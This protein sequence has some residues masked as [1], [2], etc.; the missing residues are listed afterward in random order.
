[1]LAQ[2]TAERAAVHRNAL[3]TGKTLA[4]SPEA[5]KSDQ[6][7]R[8]EHTPTRGP[9]WRLSG[10]S[11][12]APP[13]IYRVSRDIGGKGRSAVS[14]AHEPAEVEADSLAD[15]I[16][17]DPA[18]DW[19]AG[20][21][22]T[23]P[24]AARS[25]FSSRLGHD[26]GSVRVH[27]GAEAA[28]RADGIGARAFTLNSNIYFAQRRFNLQSREGRRL[29]AH[30]LIHIQQQHDGRI[31]TARVH[32]DE[33]P[34][35]DRAKRVGAYK[36]ALKKSDWERAAL[37]LN[38]FNPAD[39]ERHIADL[40]EPTLRAIRDA[41]D[42]VMKDWPRVVQ[43]HIEK[44]LKKFELTDFDRE[45]IKKIAMPILLY[46]DASISL[47]HRILMVAH[48]RLESGAASSTGQFS[49]PD[50]WNVFNL[51]V[52]AGTPN[53]KKVPRWEYKR[54]VPDDQADKVDLNETIAVTSDGRTENWKKYKKLPSGEVREFVQTWVGIPQ[55]PD[56]KEAVKGYLEFLKKM[57]KTAFTALT[58]DAKGA[59]E[60]S[61]GI[62][63]FGTGYGPDIGK[64]I[65]GFVTEMKP[66]LR[67]YA[68][69]RLSGT[70][71]EPAAKP[72]PDEENLLKQLGK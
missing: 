56:L 28:S 19:I 36:E 64:K 61:G 15:F 24:H 41:A 45:W 35:N 48:A 5:R 43:E 70:A 54:K 30:E 32:R 52:D 58:E 69:E 40:E 12:E 49:A 2:R 29:L 33:D 14:E 42:V 4:L 22:G 72:E 66:K 8:G 38:G 20:A 23:L 34:R 27:T 37:M 65:Q 59:A 50:G 63:H 67:Q 1:M 68:Q 31:S 53:T 3:V 11:I 47:D 55:Y 46:P 16:A 39:I 17:N 21:G 10:I 7:D 18:P 13:P 71:K 51:Q 57:H 9:A 6:I 44:R 62:A 26:F 25:Y 60:F